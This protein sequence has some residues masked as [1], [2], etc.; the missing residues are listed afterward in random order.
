[1][2]YLLTNSKTLKNK[3]R[4]LNKTDYEIFYAID[5]NAVQIQ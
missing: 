3:Q 5:F 2:S 4:I 1:M